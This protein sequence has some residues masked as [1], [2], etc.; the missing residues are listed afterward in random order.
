MH[1]HILE[2]LQFC[3]EAEVVEGTIHVKCNKEFGYV[4]CGAPNVA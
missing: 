2:S 1:K 4:Q 3:E